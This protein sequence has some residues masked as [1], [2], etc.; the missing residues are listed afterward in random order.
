MKKILGIIAA[1]ALAGSVFAKPDINPVIVEFTGNASLEWIANLDAQTTGMKNS[2]WTRWK[3]QMRAD[4]WGGDSNSGDGWWGELN[5]RAGGGYTAETASTA[6][7]GADY[8]WLMPKLTVEVAK[9]HFIDGDTYLN[10]D[11]KQPDF[12]VGYIAGVTAID[13]DGQDYNNTWFGAV[14]PGA[15]GYQGFTVNFGVPVVDLALAFGDNGEQKADAKEWAFKLNAALKPIDG[16]TLSAGFALDTADTKNYAVGASA[17]YKFAIDDTFYIAPFM[18]FTMNGKAM[19][20]N[21]AAIF[22]WGGNAHEWDH[23][24]LTFKNSELTAAANNW[25]TADGLSVMFKKGIKDNAGN[26]VDKASLDI[27]FYDGSLL[28]G[29]S[30]A[31]AGLKLAARYSADDTAKLGEGCVDFGLIYAGTFDIVYVDAKAS[32][33]V[34]LGLKEKNTAAKYA[35]QI[36]TKEIIANTDIYLKYEG[37]VSE[38]VGGAGAEDNFKKGTITLGT[39]I[40]L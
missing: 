3:I 32:F 33:G 12:G 14:N 18:N 36:G 5:I 22:G 11:I 23:D 17:A 28:A 4:D 10:V 38:Y 19:G 9:L 37:S 24:F 1:L 35:I 2:T 29:L 31:L 26:T 27:A 16:L 39:K 15:A 21:A 7:A 30:D 40:S 34:N 8:G 13:R 6:A 20:V 25:R